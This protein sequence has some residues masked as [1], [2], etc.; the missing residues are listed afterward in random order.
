MFQLEN[1]E[2]LQ[3]VV[4]E[5][6]EPQIVIPETGIRLKISGSLASE[7]LQV[8]MPM[9]PTTFLI[10]RNNRYFKVDNIFRL[11]PSRKVK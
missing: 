6:G 4:P 3:L 1:L 11:V 5:A 9:P 7:F 10:F 8:L 2:N